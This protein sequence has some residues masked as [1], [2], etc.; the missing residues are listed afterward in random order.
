[1][2]SGLVPLQKS[3]KAGGFSGKNY[4]QGK[5]AKNISVSVARNSP[6]QEAVPNLGTRF[7]NDTPFLRNLFFIEKYFSFSEVRIYAAGAPG[8]LATRHPWR[9]DSP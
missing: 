3:C 8:V 4:L 6:E 2:R 5:V 7:A 1:V 9:P